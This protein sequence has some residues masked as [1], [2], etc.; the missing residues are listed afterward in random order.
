LFD[1]TIEASSSNEAKSKDEQYRESDTYEAG[2]SCVVVDTPF[3]K[4][5]LSICYD[6]RFPMLYQEMAKQGAQIML[7]PSAFTYV[8]G[9][10]HWETLLRARAI[11]NQAYVVA[12]AQGGFHVNGRRTYGHSMAVDYLG[13]VQ[14][15]KVKGNGIVTIT[16]DL[17]AQEKTRNSF[18]VL[19]HAKAF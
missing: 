1:V 4:I 12:S 6:L 5:G 15:R 7:V 9:E 19:Q 10:M 16:I 14:K 2:S 3:G 18:P 17:K 8:T 11:E 13:K